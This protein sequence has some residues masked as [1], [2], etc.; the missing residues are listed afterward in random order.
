[1]RSILC[2]L[3]MAVS[4]VTPAFAQETSSE[5][6][7][8]Q[9]ADALDFMLG[10]WHTVGGVPRPDGSYT[11]SPGVLTGERAFTGGP[12]ES[13]LVRTH[14]L[15]RDANDDNPFN[16][17]YFED[18]SIYVYHPQRSVWSGIAHNTLGDRK[19]R[20][21][22]RADEEVV[23]MQRGELFEG[24]TGDIRFTY[25]DITATSFEMRI[26]YRPTPDA[27]WQMGTFRLSARRAG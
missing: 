5:A 7:P 16:I 11:R 12:G 14:N 22:V 4:I 2:A 10:V 18:I 26:D 27:V 13:I 9:S 21:F 17:S 1:M 3:L 24:V 19:W 20:D 25:Y 15:P 23:F 8:P 6:Q